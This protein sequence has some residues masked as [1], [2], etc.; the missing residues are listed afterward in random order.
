MIENPSHPTSDRNGLGSR[1]PGS[2]PGEPRGTAHFRG[3][4][5]SRYT[6]LA[7]FTLAALNLLNL[8]DWYSKRERLDP[9]G[10]YLGESEPKHTPHRRLRRFAS[11][12]REKSSATAGSGG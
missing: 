9:W 10:R 12:R 4:G 11:G 8:H 6:L 1:L 3:F 5:I 2:V 7:G